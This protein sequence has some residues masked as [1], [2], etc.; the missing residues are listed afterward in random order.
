MP[1]IIKDF[2]TMGL[3]EVFIKRTKVE[4]EAAQMA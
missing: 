1:C 3:K 2:K 4:T